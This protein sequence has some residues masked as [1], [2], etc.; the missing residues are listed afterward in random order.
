MTER[1]YRDSVH[2]II[3]VNTDT[4][5]GRLVVSLVDTPEFPAEWKQGA[6]A[7][8]KP[9]QAFQV[10]C[11]LNSTMTPQ[12]VLEGRLIVEIKLAAV[13]PAEFV[14]LR[15]SHQLQVS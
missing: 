14:I 6:L 10:N 13:R 7:G 3:R 9:E 15:F 8:A 2:N 11:G 12:D 4:S 1:I 5:E